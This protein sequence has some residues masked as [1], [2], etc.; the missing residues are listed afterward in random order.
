MKYESIRFSP[1]LLQSPAIPTTGA[2]YIFATA[3]AHQ[4]NAAND[5]SATGAMQLIGH[6]G[7][8]V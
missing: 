3:C 8:G 7:K 4:A 2:P 1:W 5:T 6:R